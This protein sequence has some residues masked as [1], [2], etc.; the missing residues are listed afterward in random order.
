MENDNIS[1]AS[2]LRDKPKLKFLSLKFTGEDKDLEQNYYDDYFDKSLIPVRF[3]TLFALFFYS[4]FGVLDVIYAPEVVKEVWIIRFGIVAPALLLAIGISF[5]PVFKKAMQ[6]IIMAGALVA[7]GGV[8][9]IM[10]IAPAPGSFSIYTGLILVMIYVYT[11]MRLRFIW[12]S[13]TGWLLVIGYEIVGI[14]L[15]EIPVALFINNNF[16]CVGAN[17][18]GMLAAYLIERQFRRDYFFTMKNEAQRLKI[19]SFNQKLTQTVNELRAALDSIKVL[20][21]LIPICAGCKKIRDDKG[22]WHRVEQYIS[23]H[24]DATFTHGLCNDCAKELYDDFLEEDDE[25]S[26]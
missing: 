18:I 1:T 24:S 10:V 22:F 19:E 5:T 23:E 20:K 16:F 8:L 11:I 7:G 21:G 3:A 2:K 25:Q 12:A 15:V 13:I 6:G 9:A 17:S 4:A 14:W 26:S